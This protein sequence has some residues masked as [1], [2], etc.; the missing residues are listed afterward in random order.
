MHGN[1]TLEQKWELDMGLE[2]L[3]ATRAREV[4][5]N[6]SWNGKGESSIETGEVLKNGSTMGLKS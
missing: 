4:R 2:R 1:E 3:T 5:G 6:Q